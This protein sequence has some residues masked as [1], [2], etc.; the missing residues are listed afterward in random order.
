MTIKLLDASET[1][2][3]CLIFTLI[4]FVQQ[5]KNKCKK[6]KT[7]YFHAFFIEQENVNRVHFLLSF[8]IRSFTNCFRRNEGY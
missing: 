8:M 5:M 4:Q 6:R 7:E 3:C 2:K 1:P